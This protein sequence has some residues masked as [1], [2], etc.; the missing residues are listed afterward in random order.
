MF[1]DEVVAGLLVGLLLNVV[2]MGV[3]LL[4]AHRLLRHQPEK[5]FML[6]IMNVVVFGIAYTMLHVSLGV[7]AAFGLFAL[8]GIL[9][10]RTGQLGVAEMSLLFASLSLAVVNSSGPSGL[11]FGELVVINV[12][13]VMAL[14]IG[15]RL[16]FRGGQANTTHVTK[17]IYDRLDLLSK[18]ER[19]ATARDLVARTG[20]EVRG[21]EIASVDLIAGTAVL[22]VSHTEPRF[23]VMTDNITELFEGEERPPVI[24]DLTSATPTYRYDIDSMQNGDSSFRG[25]T[26]S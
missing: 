26:R 10:F 4:V 1:V 9:R 15:F 23:P 16:L 25:R 6:S 22:Q 13:T 7:G 18:G 8:F 11:S 3:L 21:L 5:M 14:G 20:L 2:S 24:V 12:G 19:G 17:V